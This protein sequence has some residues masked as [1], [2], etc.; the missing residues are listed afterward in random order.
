MYL[1][2]SRGRGGFLSY[3]VS[4]K[5]DEISGGAEEAKRIGIVPNYVYMLHEH[6]SN[7]YEDNEELQ[8]DFLA[9]LV[10]FDGETDWKGDWQKGS[11][12]WNSLSNDKKAE[13]FGLEEFDQE[14]FEK[15]AF[16]EGKFFVTWDEYQKYFSR[17][18]VC[19]INK[20]TG[21]SLQ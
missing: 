5:A 21:S 3:V 6:H 1:E 11:E 15:N 19:F 16:E 18:G 2:N 7:Q 8:F 13:W 12:K 14:K 9:Q 4:K 20:G 10:G 17:Q